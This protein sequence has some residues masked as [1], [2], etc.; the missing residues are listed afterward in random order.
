MLFWA[1][2]QRRPLR[3]LSL[4]RKPGWPGGTGDRNFFQGTSAETLCETGLMTWRKSRQ[5]LDL[6]NTQTGK[7]QCSV[8]A[9]RNVGSKGKAITFPAPIIPYTE[10]Q[11]L[12]SRALKANL[13]TTG[14][15][16]MLGSVL[17]SMYWA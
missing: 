11:D 6:M 3:A 1:K 7:V 12:S 2:C 16:R 9:L 5:C 15:L 4:K 17:M 13:V 14:S 8:D 10:G